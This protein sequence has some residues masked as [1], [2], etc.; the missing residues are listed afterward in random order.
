M[1][2]EKFQVLSTKA[3]MSYVQTK[4]TELKLYDGEINCLRDKKTV[5][6]IMKLQKENGL[7]SNGIVCEKTF[8]LLKG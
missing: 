1:R 4:L 8:E 6:A 3:K 2:F 5:K 7:T